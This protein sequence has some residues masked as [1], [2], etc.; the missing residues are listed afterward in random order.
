[1]NDKTTK[2]VHLYPDL[3][4]YEQLEKEAKQLGLKRVAPYITMILTQHAN[5]SKSS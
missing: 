5:K 2:Q 4:V 3:W 1:M